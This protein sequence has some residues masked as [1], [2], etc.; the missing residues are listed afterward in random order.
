[1]QV[2]VHD[3]EAHVARS[4]DTKHRVE[5][6]SIIVHQTA[7]FVDQAGN[8]WNV[9]FENAKCIGVCHHHGSYVVAQ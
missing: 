3:V 1:M 8:F 5:V 2:D 7:A 6:G 9:V 4:A